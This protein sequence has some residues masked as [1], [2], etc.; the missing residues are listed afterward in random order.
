MDAAQRWGELVQGRLDEIE[1]LR[2]E[3]GPMGPS[4]WDQR[5]DRFAA[6]MKDAD[7]D[8][9]LLAPLRQAVRPSDTVLDVG[10]GTGRFALA[11]APHV[12]EVVAVDP[13]AGM[14]DRLRGFAAERGLTNVRCEQ[15]RWPDVDVGPADV[16]VCAYV[17]PVIAD[18]APFVRALDAAAARQVFVHL[19][20]TLP[21]VLH[22]PFWQHF[23]GRPRAQAP[24]YLDA[25]DVLAEQGLEPHVEVVEAP[26]RAR[27]A[28]LGEAVADFRDNLLLPETD[29][30]TVTLESM[31]SA[32][33]V[34]DAA[35]SLRPPVA[36]LPAAIL[37]WP[38]TAAP[39]RG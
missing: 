15:G 25:V 19:S 17:L 38:R 14:L 34:D 4:F 9:P 10:A 18:V 12:A 23:H 11:L 31:L 28:D 8:E 37:S 6:R 39:D 36:T 22:A 35:G 26:V 30:I 29:D 16:V 2:P 21:D 5:A 7:A 27:F 13:S 3:R 32:W 33:L 24:T 20:G 1:Q